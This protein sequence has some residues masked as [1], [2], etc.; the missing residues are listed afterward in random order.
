MLSEEAFHDRL[1]CVDEA[2]VAVNPV[3]ID[4]GAVSPAEA[5]DEEDDNA[6][7]TTEIDPENALVLLARSYAATA[8][9]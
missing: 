6:S 4:G 8:Y 3:G 9:A 7:V 1:T 5:D 2:A